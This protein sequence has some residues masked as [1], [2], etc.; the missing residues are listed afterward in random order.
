MKRGPK[1]LNKP[2]AYT[3]TAKILRFLAE[4]LTARE[5]AEKAG[6][7]TQTV[8]HALRTYPHL[9]PSSW[10]ERDGRRALLPPRQNRVSPDDYAAIRHALGFTQ[11]ELSRR[12]GVDLRTVQRREKGEILITNEAV[13]A[14]TSLA[15]YR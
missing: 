15:D 8:Y 12:L 4:G 3:R 1:K 6:A 13:L 14:V 2:R 9:R 10:P 11:E 5:A 7:S